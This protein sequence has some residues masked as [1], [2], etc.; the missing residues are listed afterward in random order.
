MQ[1]LLEWTQWSV[2]FKPIKYI[3]ADV[4]FKDPILL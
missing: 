4:A 3:L 2:F 1:F